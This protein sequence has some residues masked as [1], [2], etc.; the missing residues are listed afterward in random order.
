MSLQPTTLDTSLS[1]GP[2][3]SVVRSSMNHNAASLWAILA[4][5]MAILG[6]LY[7]D[8]LRFLG[9]AW[10]E[11]NNSH[12]LFIPLISLYMIW[13][14]W[15]ELKIVEHRGAWWG[16]LL[17]AAGVFVY[18]VGEFA[19]MYA[20]VQVSLWLVL[21]GLFVCAIGLSGVRIMAFPLA[22]LLVA[23]PWPTFLQGELSNRLQLWSS[24]LGVGFLHAVGITAYREGNVIDLGPTQLQVVEACSGLRYL[25]PLTA[26]TLLAAYLYRESLW[27]RV[28]LVVS[29]I[30][31]SILLNGFRIGVIGV[32]VGAY[33]QSAAE[34]FTH[35]FEGW[36]FFV[37]SLA[38]LCAEMWIL[39]RIGSSDSRSSFGDLIG[40]PKPGVT[41]PPFQSALPADRIALI[42]LVIGGT[43]L[44]LAMVVAPAVAPDELPPPPVRQPLVDFPSQLEA[45]RGVSSPM[46]RHYL[47]ALALDDY[48]MTDY[49]A[50]DQR[51]VNVYVAYYQS[52]KK[53]RSSHSPRQCIPGGGWEITSFESLP[54]APVPGAVSSW[55]VNRVVTQKDGHKQIVYYWFKQ[56]DRWITSEYLV[57]FFLFWDSLTRH[58]ADGA[59]VRLTS[60]VTAEESEAIVDG[61]LR[62]MAELVIPLL[63][64]YVPD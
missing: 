41:V 20:V 62:A 64:R 42:P 43:L 6:Y 1:S 38:L 8:S 34:G 9:E 11:D 58:R 31:I 47:D 3:P 61:R 32:L 17:L 63:R 48:V 5:V 13:L 19:A 49:T 60:T 18:L 37:A 28:V 44:L 45:W 26:L 54:M 29:S 2:E 46:E 30:P 7:A 52:P 39:A 36:I 53:G 55:S 10:L 4:V 50:A 16:L 15:P 59:L 12:G 27:K 24:A 21:V 56:R 51:P 22:Y 33:G 40:L 23:I 14:R 57:K 25:F 35:F